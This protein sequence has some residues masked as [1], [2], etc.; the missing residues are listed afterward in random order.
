[1]QTELGHTLV[2]EWEKIAESMF[3]HLVKS[4][5]RRMNGVGVDQLSVDGN[6]FE[7]KCSTSM[8]FSPFSVFKRQSVNRIA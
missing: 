3:K 8:C 7:I 4:H 5:T 2:F 1:M 6:G